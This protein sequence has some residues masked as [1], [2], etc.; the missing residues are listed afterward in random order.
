MNKMNIILIYRIGGDFSFQDIDLIASHIH[1]NSGNVSVYCVTNTFESP[2]ALTHCTLLP[3]GH[4]WRG[5][6]AKMNLF[7]PEL[8]KYRP[9]LFL[10]LDT[11]VL[12]DVNDLIEQGGISHN[13]IMLRDFYR[14]TNPASGVMWIPANN[15]KISQVWRTWNLD[16]EMWMRKY[17]GDQDFI[18]SAVKP[19]L[20]WQDIVKGIYTFK[21]TSRNWLNE[22]PED[23][24]L[25]CFHGKPRIWD[26]IS[27]VKWVYEYIQ[28]AQYG[29]G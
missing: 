28:Y 13:F 25:V 14:F 10:D 24:K 29:R 8:E 6:W 16:P 15:D 1:K 18:S 26:A 9:F 11:A 17:R 22:V 2:V 20:F 27:R 4:P 21:P 3:M 19:D 5:W 12:G 23:A 7:S